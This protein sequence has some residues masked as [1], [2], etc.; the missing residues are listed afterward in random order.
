MERA[1]EELGS[2]VKYHKSAVRGLQ[3]SVWVLI[4]L[5]FLSNTIV[6]ALFDMQ[7]N[8]LAALL[9]FAVQQGVGEIPK[10]PSKLMLA[11]QGNRL[12]IGLLVMFGSALLAVFARMRFHLAE[13]SKAEAN[14]VSFLRLQAAA[15]EGVPDDVKSAL[16]NG[17]FQ[18]E[19]S[20]EPSVNVP[21]ET[22][23]KIA[24]AVTERVEKF[25]RS[26]SS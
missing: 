24:D 2:R 3:V 13:L 12:G 15:A 17:T 10:E 22:V 23:G 19:L 18:P 14:L 11:S 9:E 16:L 4:V 7:V 20:R 25:I 8:K 1:V 6:T 5:A 21:A 26:N